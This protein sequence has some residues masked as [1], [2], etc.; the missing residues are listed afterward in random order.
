MARLDKNVFEHTVVL[1]R[2]NTC[3]FV[4]DMINGFCK[5]GVMADPDIMS[6]VPSI[7]DI[8]EVIP[9]GRLYFITDC[10]NE[11]DI[12]FKTFPEHCLESTNESKVIDE[13]QNYV[14]QGF[15]IKKNCTNAFH[16]FTNKEKFL[17]H[18]P[19]TILITGCCTD[20]CVMQFALS[21]KTYLNSINLEK[22]VIVPVDCVETYNAPHHE[23]KQR[24][25][26]ALTIMKEAGIEIV[27]SVE[28]QAIKNGA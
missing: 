5:K 20:I 3:L 21:L 4:V 16:S 26:A 10:H 9:F 25:E 28:F 13:L 11:N 14:D 27:N 24:N 15:I 12:E 19:E 18:C 22:R 7:A 1:N 23:A 8:C 6:I 17:Q 2:D